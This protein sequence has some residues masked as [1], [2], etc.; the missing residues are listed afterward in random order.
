MDHLKQLKVEW[1]IDNLLDN[2]PTPII[3][4]SIITQLFVSDKYISTRKNP[5]SKFVESYKNSTYF[6]KT[7]KPKAKKKHTEKRSISW[8]CNLCI[9]HRK[10]RMTADSWHWKVIF[11]VSSFAR[12]SYVIDKK[13]MHIWKLPR[14]MQWRASVLWSFE[15]WLVGSEIESIHLWSTSPISVDNQR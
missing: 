3:K 7:V 14:S 8:F 5:S 10:L 15:N 1:I 11:A 13:Y 4:T 2:D 6:M 9:F 12:S